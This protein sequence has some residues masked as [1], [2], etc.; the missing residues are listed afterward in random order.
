MTST[1]TIRASRPSRLRR[2]GIAG[3]AAITMVLSA[4]G[5]DGGQGGGGDGGGGGI[6]IGT[7]DDVPSLDPA[8][9]YSYMCGTIIDNVGATLVSYKPGE[10]DPSPDLAAAEPEISED[11]KTYTFKLRQGVKFH[12]G[13]DLTSEDVKFSLN[14]ARWIAH[15]DGASFLLGGIDSI[16]TPDPQTVVITLAEPDIT[17]GAKLA[18]NVATIV[19]S[20][21]AFKSPEG[22]LPEDAPQEEKDSFLNQELIAA[23]PY[24]LEEFRQNESIELS[25][26]ADYFGE[27]S[28]N[29]QVL[30]RFF[31]ESSQMQAA[32]QSGDID[33]AFR[34]LTPEQRESLQNSEDIK[35]VEGKGASIRYMVF[36]IDPK[37]KVIS[38]KSVRQ[39]I[40]ATIDRQRLVDNVLAGGA[41]PLYSMVPPLFED[42]NVPAFKD[43]YEGK[44]ASDFLDEPVSIDLWHESS[45]HYGDTETAL[46]QEIGRMLEESGMFKVNVQNAEWAQYSDNNA[47]AATSPYPTYLLGWYPDFLD[48]DNYIQPFYDS[49]GYTQNYDN[50][51]MDELIAQEQTADSSDS[52]QRMETFKEIQ[53]LAAEDAPIVPL[54]VQ[55]PFAFARNNIQGLEE[56]MDA[57]Q[58]FRFNLL[59]KQ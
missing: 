8:E 59:S 41:E 57:S 22:P 11:E 45:G 58:V 43:F 29:D 54:Y 31:A 44:N 17:F 4:C 1:R 12:D 37:N 36:N 40:A 33:V 50:P 51:K 24:T 26:F 47:P 10:T 9:C 14:R 52:P 49:K 30:V 48:P 56:T 27:P 2:A 13:S 18:Y 3:T 23:G 19:P 46:A 39:A 35:T 55:T 5:G 16:E 25:K 28:K 6:I 38:E 42:A 34:E 7:N 53:Q 20:D 15:P 32:L 21:G